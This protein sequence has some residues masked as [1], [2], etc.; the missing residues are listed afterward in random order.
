MKSKT[1]TTFLIITLMLSI[2]VYGDGRAGC[3]AITH[4]S[5]DTLGTT[6]TGAV[7]D[8]ASSTVIDI[9][10]GTEVNTPIV[11]TETTNT[12][13]Q[14][15]A[16]LT[17][18]TQT[19]GAFTHSITGRDTGSWFPVFVDDDEGGAASI[20]AFVWQDTAAAEFLIGC[21]DRGTNTF[22]V[23]PER[24][25]KAG[26]GGDNRWVYAP[27]THILYGVIDVGTTFDFVRYDCDTGAIVSS[28]NL[29]VTNT[30]TTL[31]LGEGRA[32]DVREA[33]SL[34]TIAGYGDNDTPPDAFDEGV[35]IFTDLTGTLGADGWEEVENTVDP[36]TT[37]TRM[38]ATT[39][40]SN[41]DEAYVGETD[42]LALMFAQS[43]AGADLRERAQTNFV[44]K[45]LAADYDTTGGTT[46]G[47]TGQKGT[48]D[49]NMFYGKIED[50][51]TTPTNS[52][53]LL[54]EVTG[55]DNTK[56]WDAEAIASGEYVFIGELIGDIAGSVMT[57]VD[58]STEDDVAIT[59]AVAGKYNGF[60]GRTFAIGSQL[61]GGL[62]S[63]VRAGDADFVLVGGLYTNPD[64]Q[65]T[66][67]ASFDA[68]DS[69]GRTN[70]ISSASAALDMYFTSTG[71]IPEF[72]FTTLLIAVLISGFVL[73][74][75][76]R[77]KR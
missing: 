52:F 35:I 74:F 63:V 75:I 3:T 29:A 12:F 71:N 33:S 15:T 11:I 7:T 23:T 25:G 36:T 77:R 66:T 59:N 54:R 40:D 49:L 67:I 48:T 42:T 57:L 6:T 18:S 30:Y 50:D 17:T 5:A 32:I 45:W 19:V 69:T 44:G 9:I 58:G 10:D 53:D 34:I 60:G 22:T 72:S 37:H 16:G 27:A 8:T 61:Q 31:S 26:W 62:F 20:T 4:Y 43:S 39:I 21:V 70:V 51:F 28:N 38:H 64:D 24:L 73:M 65:G 68:T 76:I 55:S 47:V 13:D 46:I 14:C 56:G 1:I 2:A 41:G